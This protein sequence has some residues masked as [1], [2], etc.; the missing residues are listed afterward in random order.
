MNYLNESFF[1]KSKKTI[2]EVSIDDINDEYLCDS[3][4]EI[5]DFDEVKRLY[6]NSIGF[7]EDVSKSVDAIFM[8][9]D[10]KII[11]VEFKNTKIDKSVRDEII[12]K[13]FDSVHILM[14][15]TRYKYE[16][17]FEKSEFIL[18]YSESKNKSAENIYKTG[19]YFERIL[20][21]GHKLIKFNLD[22]F[23]KK[24]KQEI[25]FSDIHTYNEREFEKYI[26]KNLQ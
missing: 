4:K 24:N 3:D 9:K 16:H 13:L 10:E 23:K 22:K 1:E 15:I 17:I 6:T 7:S 12:T 21:K 18:V 20:D 8:N 2:K 14:A 25:R 26:E 19:K 11:F 5:I